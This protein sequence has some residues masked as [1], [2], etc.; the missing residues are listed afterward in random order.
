MPSD[1]DMSIGG[2]CGAV[3]VAIVASVAQQYGLRGLM[4]DTKVDYSA[5]T[6]CCALFDLW[7]HMCMC[8]LYERH[9]DS[10]SVRCTSSHRES[11]NATLYTSLR[12]HSLDQCNKMRYAAVAMQNCATYPVGVCIGNKLS[13]HDWQ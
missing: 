1:S 11:R 13:H 6:I 7:L 3:P 12:L 10:L 2:C 9:C 5:F 8:M 4:N